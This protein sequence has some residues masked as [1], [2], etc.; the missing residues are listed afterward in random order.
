MGDAD[1]VRRRRFCLEVGKRET[2][3][4]LMWAGVVMVIFTAVNFAIPPRGE[5]VEYV[6]TI[7][8]GLVLVIVGWILRRPGVPA[9][10]V[11][12]AMAILVVLVVGVLLVDY[13]AEPMTTTLA[14][15]GLIMLAFGP[16]MESPPAFAVAA[17]VSYALAVWALRAT[18]PWSEAGSW[19]VVFGIALALS[20]GLLA[21][22]IRTLYALSD[23]REATQRMAT[24]DRLTG[25]LNRHGL[26]TGAA[27]LRALAL[28]QGS[29][30]FACFVDIRGLNAAND[31]WGHE[32]GD[33]VISSVAA[34]VSSCARPSDLAA[35]W[36]GDEFV[37]L[38]LGQAPDP[39]R[40]ERQVEASVREQ[41]MDVTR[42][43]GR[44]SAGC[45][46]AEPS[47]TLDVVLQSADTEMYDRRAR[48]G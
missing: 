23:A 30:Y 6:R 37:L 48:R 9:A 29:P 33:A 42:W 3:V 2:P 46:T 40:I 26:A 7:G 20:G 41:G 11:P 10:V 28:R 47:V 12:W 22:R 13:H 27:D 24:T 38:G 8:L 43:P 5:P 44:V 17:V 36:G 15:V 21:R 32:Y 1:I 14:I 16:A 31:T 45:I 18:V 35:R 39:D 19:L 34:G 25:L 4:I